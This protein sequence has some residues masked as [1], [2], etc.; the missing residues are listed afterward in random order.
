[1]HSW[2]QRWTTV[3]HL[4]QGIAGQLLQRLQPVFNAAARLVFS[5]R[6]SEHTTPLLR[7][8]HWLKV[9]ER[10]QFWLCVLA[11]RCLNGT[12]PSYLAETLRLT[13]D[14]GS[15]RHLRS[16]STSTVVI[17]S[18]RR[19]TLGDHAFQVAAAQR[20]E[21]SSAVCSFCATTAAVPLRPEDGTVPII[22]LF[23]MKSSYVTD[24]NF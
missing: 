21:C 2:L 22:V 17:P 14:V 3:A 7:K 16:A 5:T 9:L 6:K 10:I 11:Y 23:T 24:C 12:A 15:R 4:S 1:M 18:T 8:L 19:T 20:V 13:A